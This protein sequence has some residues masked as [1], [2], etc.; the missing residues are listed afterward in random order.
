MPTLYLYLDVCSF[1][2]DMYNTLGARWQMF[3]KYCRSL[4]SKKYFIK[5]CRQ[6]WIVTE[7]WF[8][9]LVSGTK[10]NALSGSLFN[11]DALLGACVMKLQKRLLAFV[12]SYRPS[13][14]PNG[15]TLLP[16]D[17]LP[18]YLTSECFW[19]S[20]ERIKVSLKADK[21]SGN[22]NWRQLYTFGHISFISS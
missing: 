10:A 14:R 20:G 9:I 6:L 11:H 13:V 7:S 5:W 15:T 1:G 18:L 19:N 22:F 12:V 16:S 17:E 21:K 4:D 2:N 3:G 8:I